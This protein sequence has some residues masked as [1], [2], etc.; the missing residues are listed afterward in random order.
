[1]IWPGRLTSIVLLFLTILFAAS[2]SWSQ[3]TPAPAAADTSLTTSEYAA[4]GFPG[5]DKPWTEDDYL[6]ALRA[7]A[8]LAKSDPAKLP[9]VGSEKSG[10][11]IARIVSR[12]NLPPADAPLRAM[13]LKGICGYVNF[14][15]SHYLQNFQKDLAPTV[16]ELQV[17]NLYLSRLNLEAWAATVSASQGSAREIAAKNQA[18]SIES[19]PSAFRIVALLLGDRA[20]LSTA[21]RVR[22]ADAAVENMPE[23]LS[24]IKP[25]DA[26]AF[27]DKVTKAAQSEPD[28][29]L[30]AR[31]ISLSKIKAVEIPAAAPK[32]ASPAGMAAGQD[33]PENALRAYI[34]AARDGDFEAYKALFCQQPDEIAKYV[35]MIEYLCKGKSPAA[36]AFQKS[37]NLETFADSYFPDGHYK[38]FSLELQ[39]DQASIMVVADNPTT[40]KPTYAR[41]YFKKVGGK[42]YP[43]G[44]D[45]LDSK[46]SDPVKYPPAIV[47][48]PDWIDD[49]PKDLLPAKPKETREPPLAVTDIQFAAELDNDALRK[50]NAAKYA[51]KWIEIDGTVLDA[52]SSNR[53][54]VLGRNETTKSGF[55]MSRVSCEISRPFRRQAEEL[56]PTQKVKIVGMFPEGAWGPLLAEC[57]IIS[58]GPD[59][60]IRVTAAGLAAELA[61]GEDATEK[62]YKEKQLLIEGVVEAVQAGQYNST[63]ELKGVEKGGK[64]IRVK[65]SGFGEAQ[66]S[67]VGKLNKGQQ[68]RVKGGCSWVSS[69]SIDISSCKLLA[70]PTAT[71]ADNK[72][73]EVP[74]LRTWTDR[75]GKHKVEARFM[76][77]ADGKV[78]L[79]KADGTII[80][81]PMDI[82]SPADQDYLKRK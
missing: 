66:F 34:R 22:V 57:R 27:R 52:Y 16:V 54:L 39:G 31:L 44:H 14:I 70:A 78:Q 46:H 50:T 77:L 32:A 60:A 33:S 64:P 53:L 35:Q 5:V 65:C 23:L 68:V 55:H 49:G 28:A 24:C 7:V 6:K 73:A 25:E 69:D 72:P 18:N 76:G 9:R 82:L 37:V 42:W 29:A 11:L 2:R 74:P 75:S 81:I 71:G 30:K 8:A 41:F 19:L 67:E 61:A 58:V 15:E 38:V 79:K 3:S 1:L 47:Q 45:L 59:P 43:T 56:T 48:G 17:F 12:D 20:D 40:K 21:D 80:S 26:A 4:K 10:P 63:V 13:T 51:N 36:I 62:K